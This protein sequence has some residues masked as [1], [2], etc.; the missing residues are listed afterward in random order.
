M[1]TFLVCIF[2]RVIE[3]WNTNLHQ[4]VASVA[5]TPP[6][7]CYQVCSSSIVAHDGRPHLIVERNQKDANIFSSLFSFMTLT[8]YAPFC[9]VL[10]CNTICEIM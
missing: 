5:L 4:R 10:N 8:M 9:Y 6:P 1:V 7:S 2:A 3:S